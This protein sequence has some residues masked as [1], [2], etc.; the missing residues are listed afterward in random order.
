ML[1]DTSIRVLRQRPTAT[2]RSCLEGAPPGQR[3]VR[4]L[5]I[6]VPFCFHKCHYC[7]FYSLVDTRDRQGPFVERLA[8]ELRALA[9]WAAGSPLETIF[10]GGGTPSL[11]RSELWGELLGTLGREFDLSLMGSGPGEFT[12]E[13]NPETVTPHLMDMLAAGGVNRV[14]MGAQSFHPQHLKTLERWHNPENVPKALEMARAAGIVRQ[15]IDLIFG[16][17]GQTLDDW[18]RD[19]ETALACGTEHLSCYNLTYEAGTAMTARLSRGEFGRADEDLEVDMYELT[20]RMLRATGMERYEVSNYARP[21]AEA[22]HN[23]AYW[24]QEQW[25]A[26]GPSASAHVAG[27]RWKNSPRL[28]DYLET[29]DDGFAPVI[30]FEAPDPARALTESIMTRLRLA[31]G[32]DALD[33]LTRAAE[34]HPAA[35]GALERFAAGYAARGLL[36]LEPA[37]LDR[38]R[39]TDAGFLIADAV[40]ADLMGAVR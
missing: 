21:G 20:L 5:Y 36:L 25:L 2:A 14:S 8:R 23:L 26:A 18:R 28:D 33:L 22:R 35:P 24:R 3:P 1:H 34:V 37:P 12:V 4:S 13:C 19:L 31:E 10:V 11:L 39:L 27:R 9:P 17:P 32:L 38:W 16:I 40:A 6:H 30:D 7:D 15:S 29:D